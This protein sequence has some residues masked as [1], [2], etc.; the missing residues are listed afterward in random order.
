[1]LIY[2]FTGWKYPG[3]I[4]TFKFVN[5]TVCFFLFHG[6]RTVDFFFK[7][8]TIKLGLNDAVNICLGNKK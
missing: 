6:N 4:Q 3:W 2:R 7:N 8:R 5:W 1:M